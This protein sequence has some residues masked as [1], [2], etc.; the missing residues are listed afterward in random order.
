MSVWLMS[1]KLTRLCLNSVNLTNAILNVTDTNVDSVGL[2][3]VTETNTE[4]CLSSV[5][6]PSIILNDTGTPISV[7]NEWHHP[8][9]SGITLQC[10]LWCQH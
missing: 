6:F 3:D 4:L 1:Q 10:R 9:N 8:C 5:G 2:I 7:S